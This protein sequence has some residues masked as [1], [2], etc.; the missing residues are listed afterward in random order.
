M[1][2]ILG[3]SNEGIQ[4]I[5]HRPL[6]YR[7]GSATASNYF[8]HAITS[9]HS[10]LEKIARNLFNSKIMTT[11][12]QQ[13]ALSVRFHHVCFFVD[14]SKNERSRRKDECCTITDRWETLN[15]PVS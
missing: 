5:E 9:L 3:G 6:K 15:P 12:R 14:R 2:D 8:R 4:G 11:A 7:I 1:F 13:R 10:A